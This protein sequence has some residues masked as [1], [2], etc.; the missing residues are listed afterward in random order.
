MASS[1]TFVPSQAELWRQN[2]HRLQVQRLGRQREGL[3]QML[4]DQYDS[5]PDNKIS[6]V[7][8]ERSEMAYMSQ[9]QVEVMHDS[10]ADVNTD[11]M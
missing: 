8:Y 1:R 5:S 6:C 11:G 2:H 4:R 7:R 9:G 10:T 3:A